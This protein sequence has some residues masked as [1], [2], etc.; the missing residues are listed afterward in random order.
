MEP[1][2]QG[3]ILHIS[4]RIVFEI[5]HCITEYLNWTKIR[6]MKGAD[7]TQTLKR[8]EILFN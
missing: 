5:V 7:L 1:I 8:K 4:Q 3:L 2:E 6:S